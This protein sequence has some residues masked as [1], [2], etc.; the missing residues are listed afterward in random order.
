MSGL[1][2]EE[3]EILL[4]GPALEPPP[5]SIVEFVDPPGYRATSTAVPAACLTIATLAIVMLMY[6][7]LLIFRKVNFSDFSVLI[8]WGVYVGYI[9][10]MCL[11]AAVAPG[12][13]Q[14]NIQLRKLPSFLYY[15]HVSSVMYGVC[16]YFIKLSILLQYI[17]V[18][19][20]LKKPPVIYWSAIFL[21]ISNFTFYLASTFLEIF[22]CQPIAK[23]WDPLITDGHCIDILALNVAAST[24]N[25][26]SD[27]TILILPQL[28]IWRLNVSLKRK[29][30][31]S[32]I[33]LIAIFACV[34]SA[35]RLVYTVQLQHSPDIT[36]YTWFCGLWSIPEMAC[37]IVVACLPVSKGFI[38]SLSQNKAISGIASSL[39]KL[40]TWTNSTTSHSM[41]SSMAKFPRERNSNEAKSPKQAKSWTRAYG[42]AGLFSQNYSASATGLRTSDSISLENNSH[43]QP[44][45]NL[46][47]NI[48]LHDVV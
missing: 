16:I 1:T 14:W 46:G 38:N 8:A 17:H 4:S 21:I 11:A 6:T 30:E 10:I 9:A 36:Y 33:F 15:V 39:R 47:Y 31:I 34:A 25:T 22:S 23:S 26:V 48:E 3:I 44:V 20:P 40:T 5:G 18:F 42:I 35:I 19:L 7:R 37:G 24:I 2:P 13:H 32:I 12:V 27:I 29:L 41:G 45:E 43:P 28:V